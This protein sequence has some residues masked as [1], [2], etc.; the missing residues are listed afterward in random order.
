MNKRGSYFILRYSTSTGGAIDEEIAFGMRK[1]NK[2]KAH[3]EYS[4]RKRMSGR[5]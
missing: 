3:E 4:Q 5:K 1:E 2:Q